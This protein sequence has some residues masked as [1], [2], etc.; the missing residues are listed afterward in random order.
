MI[1]SDFTEQQAYH[2]D[3]RRRHNRLLH[4]AGVA[5]GLGVTGAVGATSV[6]VAPGTAIDAAGREVVLL[7]P[8]TVPL[9]AGGATAVEIYIAYQEAES[10][11]RSSADVTG[12][13]RISED[14][15]LTARVTAPAP[16]AVPAGGIL[17]AQVSLSGGQLTA[18]PTT[19]GQTRSGSVIGDDVAVVGL[20][21]PAGWRRVRAVA[22]ALVRPGEPGRGGGRPGAPGASGDARE[23]R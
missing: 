11:P 22:T 18:A 15:A 3:M 16:G 17:L 19:A 13:T 14:P 10:D 6:S 5:E 23:R 9:P 4:T 8:R 7:D 12:N 1:E 21:A 20:P 2:V